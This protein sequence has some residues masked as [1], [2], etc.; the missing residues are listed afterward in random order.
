MQE[1]KQAE[2]KPQKNQA[3]RMIAIVS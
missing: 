3:K 2:T 1:N